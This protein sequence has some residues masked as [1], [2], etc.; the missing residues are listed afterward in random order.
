MCEAG[1]EEGI[2]GGLSATCT[3]FRK[4]TKAV[5]VAQNKQKIGFANVVNICICRIEYGRAQTEADEIFATLP[6]EWD[7]IAEKY[8]QIL[9]FVCQLAKGGMNQTDEISAYNARKKIFENS[10]KVKVVRP[11]PTQLHTKVCIVDSEQMVCR[12]T[13][14][15]GFDGIVYHA[16]E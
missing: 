1:V 2:H 7:N 5:H 6:N 3:G 15:K 16:M 12:V 8:L 9:F 11:F 13:Y 4:D 14:L 10:W